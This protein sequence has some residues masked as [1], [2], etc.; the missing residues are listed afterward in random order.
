[1][2]TR[3]G[4]IAL[5]LFLLPA[6]LCAGC[7]RAEHPASPQV[8]FLVSASPDVASKATLY[9]G[10]L[11]AASGEGLG[12]VAYRY[13]STGAEASAWTLH[14]SPAVV[15]AVYDGS[16][17]DYTSK[18]AP[19][20]AERLM[21]P[22]DGWFVRFFAY[23][24]YGATGVSVEAATGEAP[25]L[26]YT[27]QAPASQTDLLVSSAASTAECSGD[28]SWQ[29]LD[30][31]LVMVH[32]LTGVRFRVPA[33]L[34]ITSVTLSGVHDSGSID[35][36]GNPLAWTGQSGSASYQLGPLSLGS[37]LH[38]ETARPGYNI[39]DND[40]ILLLMPQTLP[41]GAK[42]NVELGDGRSIAASIAGTAWLPGKLLT[43]TVTSAEILDLT[44]TVTDFED[45]IWDRTG[46][47]FE[48]YDWDDGTVNKFEG[49]KW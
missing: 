3:L 36:S 20:P 6:L 28:P 30:V 21:W 18:W 42:I 8:S 38:A 39:L 2:K 24:P 40:K 32:A 33:E 17:G 9:S 19:L 29:E 43:Y 27:V 48:D 13:G 22:G 14:S 4:N 23:F 26:S 46:N 35:L 12:I 1:M 16:R 41:S 7:R 49:F 45:I 25:V 37:G 15:K 44:L 34:D 11:A 5:L 10:A 47:T 31:P